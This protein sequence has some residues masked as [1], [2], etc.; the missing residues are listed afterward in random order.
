MIG[1][2][3]VSAHLRVASRWRRVPAALTLI[4]LGVAGR[5]PAERSGA[6]GA[7]RHTADSAARSA[8]SA[9]APATGA[10]SGALATIAA[11][12]HLAGRR[13]VDRARQGLRLAPA[14]AGSSEINTANVAQLQ[15]RVRPSR[16][17]S[18]RGQEAAPLVVGNTMYVVTPFPNIRLR[19]RSDQARRAGEVD[20]TSRSRGGA[21]QGVAC[22]D[23]VNRGAAYADG[24][25]LLQHAR[26]PHDRASTPRP[27]RRS[28]TR[29]L[30][31]INM[32]ET[33]TMA[34]LVVKGKVLVGNSG[35]EFGVR[36]WLTALDAT[37]GKLAWRAYS[38][39]PDKDV[40]IGPRFK[41]FYA[42]D[43]GTDLGVTT[44][45]R[46]RL[47]DR[48]RHGVGLDLLR[49]RAQSDLLR[50]RAIP[51][52]GIPSSV[53]ATTS[54]PPAIFA[55]DPDTGEARLVLP[56]AARTT[57]TTTTAIN[58]QR[59]ARPAARRADAR[60]V[61][62]RPDRNGY[63]YVIDRTT[64][65]VLSAD[66]FGYVNSTKGVDLKTGRL[67]SQPGEGAARSA[68]SCAT[69]ARP[70]P[71]PRT[72][73]RP[74]FSP[75]TGLL[76]IPHQNLCMDVGERARRT[77]S[78]ARR[79]SALNVK[80]YA[81]PGGNRGE[82]TAWDP[83]AR[84]G[85]LGDQG[86]LPGL[87]RH[88]RRPPAT[89]SSTARWTAGSRRSTRGPAT[90]LWQ[91]KTGSG[92]IGQPIT[93]RGPDGKQYVAVLSGVGGWAGRDR[94]RRPRRR[95][96]R[97]AALGFVNAMKDLPEQDHEG[98]HA[99]CLRAALSAC[100]CSLALVG[101]SLGR[102][103]GRR[104]QRELRVCA[105]PEQP[106]LLQRA[107]RGL[108]EPDR[109]A[110][111]PASCTR[112]VEYT[113][114]AQRRGFVR[115]TLNAGALRRRDRRAAAASSWLAD[116]APVLPLDLRLRHPAR[117]R[118]RRHA[119]STIRALRTLRIGVQ[120]IGDD[121]ANTPPAHALAQPRHRR[122]RRRLHGLRRLLAA[123]PAGPDRRRGRAGR[124]RRRRRLGPARRLLREPRAGAARASR[125]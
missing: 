42:Q 9:A 122:Q 123:Q 19:A 34:P 62:V 29:K 110:A 70:R 11:A 124:G 75:R 82:F 80:M 36:G 107:R 119:R 65:E 74:S 10:A 125:R 45:P 48:R 59:P 17:A 92:I 102:G 114:W 15:A 2:A 56:D 77:T 39:G 85:G 49:P 72:G 27:A 30:G 53:P 69:S 88:R 100:R 63:L 87:E 96:T 89:S 52:R 116:D 112:R 97:T 47:E 40:L 115:N 5:S 113:W 25:D 54:G 44:W 31:D 86:G 106:A 66:P 33:I 38:T 68:R 3:P 14:S 84:K 50:H 121:G 117:P 101:C 120:L 78:P 60:K 61:L 55:R 118:P 1:E 103:A 18:S 35:G 26:R 104:R 41:P 32:G 16:P 109:R 4:A 12:S 108:R 23:V 20:S 37:T 67:Q 22:C 98:R 28:G 7:G 79:T 21:S 57:C 64:G 71:A 83:V 73:S 13:P 95:A 24:Q 99:L 43:R 58:E 76:Y 93:Y 105:D 91:F 51:A 6:V 46:R 111:S 8:T 94:R 81:G 90:L